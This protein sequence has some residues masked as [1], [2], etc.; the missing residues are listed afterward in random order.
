MSSACAIST[1]RPGSIPW[2]GGEHVLNGRHAYSYVNSLCS[3]MMAY[4]AAGSEKHL[5]A[6]RNAFAMLQAQSYATGGWGPDEMLRGPGSDALHDSL[7]NTHHHFETPCGSYAHF[8]LTR[9][10]LRATGDSR[11]GDSMERVMYNTVLGALPLQADGRNFYYSDY[12]FDA[13]R[14]Y[15]EA[16]WACCSGTLPQIAADYRVNLYLRGPRAVY[17]NLYVPS[18]LQWEDDGARLL[19]T[20][21]GDYPFE[22]KVSFSLEVS[23]PI[24]MTLNF[25]IPA[26][27]RGARI[28]VNGEIQPA[29]VPGQFAAV[30]RVWR[31]GDQVELLLPLRSR[32][33][34]IDQ[35]HPDIVALVRGPMVLMPVK[36]GLDTSIPTLTRAALLN[37]ER[38]GTRE[39]RAEGVTLAP[40]TELGD[41]PYTAYVKLA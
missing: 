15:K 27:A 9:Y 14:V 19:L 32:L 4:L 6:A 40:F 30:R 39:W 23:R 21:V 33:E 31:S 17:V 10:L 26:W 11:F 36:P 3:A 8:K 25:R 37:A 35:R 20:Q 2:R 24:S 29:P 18:T 16:R 5:R 13:R 34:P 12:N 22:G 1:T 41:R 38:A 28:R 7:T